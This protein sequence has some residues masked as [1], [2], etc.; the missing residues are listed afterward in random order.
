MT[1]VGSLMPRKPSSHTVLILPFT[2]KTPKYTLPTNT[3]APV[4]PPEPEQPSR[5]SSGPPANRGPGDAGNQRAMLRETFGGRLR[6]EEHSG[7][8]LDDRPIN[9][10]D[11]MRIAKKVRIKSGLSVE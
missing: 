6:I 11:L 5:Y 7:F 9:Y 3:P 2:G 8:F 10:R 4:V 1:S